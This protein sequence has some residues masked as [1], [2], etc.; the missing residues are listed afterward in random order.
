M[1][2][3][4]LIGIY[5]LCGIALAIP[6]SDEGVDD[7]DGTAE[8]PLFAAKAGGEEDA[9]HIAPRGGGGGG[10][11][12]EQGKDLYSVIVVGKRDYN[13]GILD[14]NGNE[15]VF[16]ALNNNI[17]VVGGGGS[18]TLEEKGGD[19]LTLEL[20]SLS[21]SSS[22]SSGGGD[23]SVSST[24]SGNTLVKQQQSPNID[25]NAL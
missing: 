15:G 21:S 3:L 17:P 4:V 13:G 8:I 23:S 5:C 22:S 20:A 6:I 1:L 11:R 2:L 18:G 12:E 7:Y 9:L 10:G 24:S 25:P 19:R 16:L 14:G